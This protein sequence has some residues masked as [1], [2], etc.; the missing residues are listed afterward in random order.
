M[1]HS[2]PSPSVLA[3]LVLILFALAGPARP[4]AAA[5][6]APLASELHERVDRVPVTVQPLYGDAHRG[7]M[8]I[9]QFRPDGDGPFPAVI[10]H[11]GRSP[12]NRAETP[13]F[14]YLDV[15]RYWTR[16]GFAVFVPTRIGYGDAGLT[17]DPEDSGRCQE[18]QYDVAARAVTVQSLA[19][20]DFAQRQPWVDPKR[21]IVMGQSMGGFTTIVTMAAR[22]AG[23][24]A[25][26][27]FA[28]GG[29]GD[30][31]SRRGNPCSPGRMSDVFAAAGRANAGATPTLWLYAENDGYWGDALPRRWFAAYTEAGGKGEFVGFP[32]VGDEGHR[33]LA[34]GMALWRPVLDRFL[35]GLGVKAPHSVGAPAASGWAAIDDP[36]RVPRVKPE[37]R[38]KGYR[39]FLAAD[40][41]R[42]FAIGPKGE[43][44]YRTGTDAMARTLERCA[45]YA[46]APCRL[47]AVDDAVVWR[48]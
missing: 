34:R 29:G 2:A 19:A 32:P 36:S 42:A 39:A 26:I 7:E 47:Y 14:R 17:P 41:P 9:T 48:E 20:I 1:S 33:L 22:H 5:E 27:N 11:H 46:G 30:P 43:W 37:V 44:A 40:V 8:I 6:A 25:G 24:I 28:G 31:A 21:I 10:M 4:V 13:R 18:R 15:V 12:T 3:A 23:V 16:R 45:E 38:E 35:D